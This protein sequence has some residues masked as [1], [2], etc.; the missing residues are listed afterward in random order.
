MMSNNNTCSTQN[1]NRKK[2]KKGL[3]NTHYQQQRN[4]NQTTPCKL[5]DCE[6]KATRR[7][8]CEPHYRQW[9][10][11]NEAKPCSIDGCELPT[12]ALEYCAKHLTRFQR[13]GDPLGIT[14]FERTV[15]INAAKNEAARVAAK[16]HKA[17]RRAVRETE[18]DELAA[19]HVE[20]AKR[21]QE[22]ADKEIERLANRPTRI[23]R[24][25]SLVELIPYSDCEYWVGYV[26]RD[27][28]GLFWD[29]IKNQAA[30]RWLYAHAHGDIPDGLHIRHSC[31]NGHLG[32]V[33]LHHMNI[34]T[35]ADNAMDRMDGSPRHTIGTKNG[36]AKLSEAEVL[37]IYALKYS[38][39]TQKGL[40]KRYNISNYTIRSI[41]RGKTWSSV[42]GARR[43]W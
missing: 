14:E 32:C 39:V 29:G 25:N 9:R 33:S 19:R 34:G 31:H 40:A 30:H 22:K 36:C 21:R 28:Y 43:V 15:Q 11:A 12:I 6:K 42:T 35:N 18:A 10:A 17:E 3:C 7:G 8:F 4:A 5:D 16:K 20:R 41:W 38:G 24:F 23:E 1:C 27:G 13:L 2:E 26:N 37:E